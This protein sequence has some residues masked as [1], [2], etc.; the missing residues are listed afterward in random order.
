MTALRP[1]REG[2]AQGAQEPVPPYDPY[3]DTGAFAAAVELLDD[4]LND[5]LP[6]RPTPP[7][8]PEPEAQPRHQRPQEPVR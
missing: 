2:A 6:G 4:P 1:E 3:E 5:P 7:P 8:A